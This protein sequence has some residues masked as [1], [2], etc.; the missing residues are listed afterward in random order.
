MTTQPVL[1]KHH[2]I[3]IKCISDNL[4]IYIVSNSDLEKYLEVKDE[5]FQGPIVWLFK[6]YEDDT[7]V[8]CVFYLDKHYYMID[9]LPDDVDVNLDVTNFKQFNYIPVSRKDLTVKNIILQRA[10]IIL[11]LLD[12]KSEMKTAFKIFIEKFDVHL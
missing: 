7:D 8:V 3:N 9:I 10:N 2:F 4:N 12:N 5:N 6:K 1:E 11:K